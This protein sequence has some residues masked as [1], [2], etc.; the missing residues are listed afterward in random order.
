[1]KLMYPESIYPGEDYEKRRK[2]Y[3]KEIEKTK[4]EFAEV[5]PECIKDGNEPTTMPISPKFM[6]G[7]ETYD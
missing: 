3:D 1:M 6:G 7:H 2:G 5:Y 4:I